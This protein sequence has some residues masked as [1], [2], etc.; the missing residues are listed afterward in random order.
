MKEGL[1]VDRRRHA[2]KRDLIELTSFFTAIPICKGESC[3]TADARKRSLIIRSTVG[4]DRGFF[5]AAVI[6]GKLVVGATAVVYKIVSV[7]A[8]ISFTDLVGEIKDL[9]VLSPVKHTVELEAQ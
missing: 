6:E 5:N 9:A 3:G 7:K 8:L 1:A 4:K 2:G